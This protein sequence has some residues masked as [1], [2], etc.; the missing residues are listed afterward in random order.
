M[1]LVFTARCDCGFS[2][3]VL[4][5]CGFEGVYIDQFFCMDCFSL[6][7]EEADSQPPK[8]GKCGS[9]SL[10]PY[11]SPGMPHRL[12]DGAIMPRNIDFPSV[13]LRYFCPG[14]QQTTL[15]F[16]CNGFWD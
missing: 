16:L 9:T 11:D 1:G 8:C 7:N 13:K 14:C 4:T 5:G 15:K 2:A 3:E 6:V 12:P 10:I